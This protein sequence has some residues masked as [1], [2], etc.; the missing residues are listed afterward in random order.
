M[1][2]IKP[3]FSVSTNWTNEGVVEGQISQDA[4][5]QVQF[6][7]NLSFPT[8]V[9]QSTLLILPSYLGDTPPATWNF[10]GHAVLSIATGLIVGQSYPTPIGTR[11]LYLN[12]LNLC[13]F[14]NVA[15]DYSLR[16][17]VPKWFN[18]V[19]YDVYS[20]HG[21]GIPDLESKLNA[22]YEHIGG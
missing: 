20:Y 1:T 21:E 15:N 11:S 9:H 12:R 17:Q 10:A 22:V 19:R 2:S 5:G 6:I 4:G 16:I 14:P 3:N 7:G 13:V 18:H 8:I